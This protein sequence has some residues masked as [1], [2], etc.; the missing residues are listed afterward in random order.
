MSKSGMVNVRMVI[1]EEKVL[2]NIERVQK[3]INPKSKKQ[4][5][6]F[7][8]NTAFKDVI[9]SIKDYFLLMKV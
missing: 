8:E 9:Q 2:A 3:F 6:Q 5:I 1:T 7:E 4:I